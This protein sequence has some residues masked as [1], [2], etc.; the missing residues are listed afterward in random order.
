MDSSESHK[1]L[2]INSY[3]CVL[4]PSKENCFS[5]ESCK[6]GV[7]ST[8]NVLRRLPLVEVLLLGVAL[9]STSCSSNHPSLKSQDLQIQS[10]FPAETAVDTTNYLWT[11]RR[12]ELV[13]SLVVVTDSRRNLALVYGLDGTF[14]GTVGEYG[15]GPGEF[16]NPGPIR[17]DPLTK[18]V[19]IASNSRFTL[20]DS[21]LKYVSSFQPPAVV[22]GFDVLADGNLVISTNPTSERGSLLKVSRSGDVLWDTSPALS[23]GNFTPLAG[24]FCISDVVTV[25]SEIW[26]VYTFFNVIREYTFDG[27]F[28]RE[29]SVE[30]ELARRRNAENLHKLE[31]GKAE[32]RFVGPT[33]V[34]M[35]ARASGGLVWLVGTFPPSDS[36]QYS[37]IHYMA[38][39]ET[40]RVTE[41]YALQNEEIR[42]TSDVMVFGRI[43]HRRLLI[44]AARP[45][46]FLWCEL[47]QSATR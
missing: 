28:V 47:D 41:L 42:H 38:L 1:G 10:T 5:P 35:A 6:R 8:L 12:F 33:S 32:G 16:I 17:S 37:P 19:W 23:V 29:F 9:Y 39:D 25:G 13:D 43:N 18:G 4:P 21:D 26:Q 15:Q 24:F 46:R 22:H 14:R 20:L 45:P 27:E 36:D 40:G 2:S 11:P 31:K 7:R 44:L 30:H 34:F 3:T